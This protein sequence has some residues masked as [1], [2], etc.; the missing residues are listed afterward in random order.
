MASS[1]RRSVAG[2]A[3]YYLFNSLLHDRN[4]SKPFVLNDS[5]GPALGCSLSKINGLVGWEFTAY[6]LRIVYWPL[7][8]ETELLDLQIDKVL[9]DR[10]AISC[11]L[12]PHASDK[13]VNP[14]TV[15]EIQITPSKTLPYPEP[16]V[17]TKHELKAQQQAGF[18]PDKFTKKEPEPTPHRRAYDFC[19]NSYEHGDAA[20]IVELNNGEYDRDAFRR[21]VAPLE[22]ELML[23]NGVLSAS[24]A[25]QQVEVTYRAGLD[26]E[27]LDNFV[28][29]VVH[30][31]KAKT[32]DDTSIFYQ[33]KK[34]APISL[35]V[36]PWQACTS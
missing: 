29:M 20:P 27:L 1:F 3:R 35:F 34:G 24:V 8:T 26:I 2:V 5:D 16:R 33:L 11:E 17:F 28:S 32:E 10:T 22:E 14:Y 12:F 6:Y 7:A 4:A 13:T 25:R 21:L 15:D 9:R 19:K 30:R 18:D 23:L 36:R 31:F